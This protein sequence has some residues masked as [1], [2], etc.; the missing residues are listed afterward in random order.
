MEHTECSETSAYK[1][2]TPGNY[3]GGNIQQ[4]MKS[5]LVNISFEATFV[6]SPNGNNAGKIVAFLSPPIMVYRKEIIFRC[7][8]LFRR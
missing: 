5:L 3:P 1:I 8:G 7:I 4:D 6:R 2:Q